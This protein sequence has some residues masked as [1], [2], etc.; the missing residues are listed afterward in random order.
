VTVTAASGRTTHAKAAEIL[1]ARD[2][3]IARLVAAAGPPRLRRPQSSHYATLVQAIVYQQL[4]GA[5]AAT[6]HRRVI[7]ALDGDVRPEAV[8]ALSVE[9]L[10]GAGLSAAKVASLRDLA[11]K[12]LD[13]TVV[14]APRRLARQS[15][16]EIVDRLSAV[17]GIGRWTAEMFLIFQLGRLDVWPVGDYGVRKGYA[18]AY[19]LPEPPSPKEL[20]A[21]GEPFRPYRS[22]AAW[23]CWRAA[24]AVTPG[25]RG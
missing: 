2:P 22:V 7:S 18:L 25:G 1:A 17:R 8:L 12:V 16:Q 19:G 23:Y 5:A 6:I 15:D 13:E 3:V 11:S 4:A 9:T 24:E 10:R 21:L 20:A 14:L